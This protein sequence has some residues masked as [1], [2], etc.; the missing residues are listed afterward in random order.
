MNSGAQSVWVISSFDVSQI[1][2]VC[3][4]VFSVGLKQGLGRKAV[5]E[6][7]LFGKIISKCSYWN[8]PCLTASYDVVFLANNVI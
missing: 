3:I 7:K 8:D 1:K 5:Y 4:C 6:R 2:T